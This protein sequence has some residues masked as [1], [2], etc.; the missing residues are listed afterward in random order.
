MAL[1]YS[2]ILLSAENHQCSISDRSSLCLNTSNE[3]ESITFQGLFNCW[4][5][6]AI[7]IALLVSN[8]NPFSYNLNSPDVVQWHLA[9]QPHRLVIETLVPIVVVNWGILYCR[10]HPPHLHHHFNCILPFCLKGIGNWWLGFFATQAQ[11]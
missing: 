9:L 2:N 10:C 11:L 7:Q 1:I 3:E 8:W 5:I 6:F 4:I